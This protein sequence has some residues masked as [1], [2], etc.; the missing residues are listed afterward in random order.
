LK[1][2]PNDHLLFIG[3]SITNAFRM[4]G[5]VNDAYQMGAGYAG[6]IAARLKRDRPDLRLRFSNRG[7]SGHGI[8]DLAHRWRGDCLDLSPSVVSILV[9][10]NDSSRHKLDRVDRFEAQLRDLIRRTRE[11]VEGVRF[12]LLE[13]FASPGPHCCIDGDALAGLQLR[14]AAVQ[15]VAD[16]VDAAFVALQQPFDDATCLASGDYWIYDGIHPTAAGHMLL[17]DA[18]L[19]AITP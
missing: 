16:D 7:I 10:I 11:E 19:Q 4:P 9:G 15:R 1:L 3:D 5:E 8:D 12:T 13:P 17:A 14:Q 6:L 2:A 18:W